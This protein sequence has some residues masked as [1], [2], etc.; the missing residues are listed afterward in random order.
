MKRK[1]YTTEQIILILR[2]A[3]T[4]KTVEE[5]C[6]GNNLSEHTFYRWGKNDGHLKLA[7]VKG[8]I[9]LE[10]EITEL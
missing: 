1:R 4:G 2:H 8:V 9:E 10:K 6:R 7:D 3:D 5:I